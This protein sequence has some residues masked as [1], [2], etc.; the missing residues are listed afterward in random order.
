VAL[1]FCRAIIRRRLVDADDADEH[2]A[3]SQF[4]S[5]NHLLNAVELL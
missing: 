2:L 4:A 5:G 3:R 1:A